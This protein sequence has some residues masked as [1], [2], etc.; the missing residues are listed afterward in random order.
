[1][2]TIVKTREELEHEAQIREEDRV[3]CDECSQEIA[4]N[5]EFE[6][7]GRILCPACVD[8]DGLYA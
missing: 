3:W 6:C 1:V 2:A 4:L 8:P 5:C 7:D